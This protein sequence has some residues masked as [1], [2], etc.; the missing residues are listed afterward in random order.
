[1]VHL[2]NVS[3]KCNTQLIFSLFFTFARNLHTGEASPRVAFVCRDERAEGRKKIFHLKPTSIWAQACKR[4]ISV[5]FFSAFLIK[6]QSTARAF[7]E[8]PPRRERYVHIHSHWLFSECFFMWSNRKEKMKWK[9]I[10]RLSF[11]PVLS[12][13]SNAQDEKSTESADVR[14]RVKLC[15]HKI[16]S[17]RRFSLFGG[18]FLHV[19]KSRRK[20]FQPVI[21]QF[22][23]LYRCR[24]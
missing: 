22:L 18:N 13:C 3:I 21:D 19:K 23:D 14:R 20:I 5:C 15:K 11:L 2:H 8:P 16:K 4:K 24:A 9:N 17:E 7:G 1:M 10:P 12:R 6:Q